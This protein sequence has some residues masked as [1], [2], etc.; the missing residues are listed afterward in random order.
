MSKQYKKDLICFF[1]G[2][3]EMAMDDLIDKY[4]I[5]KLDINRMYR[6]IDKYIKEDAPETKDDLIV[7]LETDFTDDVQE[8][9]PL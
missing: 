6:Y 8:C 9:A 1:D 7:E 2:S 4:E 3:R 5:T